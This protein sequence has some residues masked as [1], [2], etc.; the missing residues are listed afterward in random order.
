MLMEISPSQLPM[1]VCSLYI[2]YQSFALFLDA[3][4]S[5]RGG[6]F[7]F[8]FLDILFFSRKNRGDPHFSELGEVSTSVDALCIKMR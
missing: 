7:D 8:F 2:I 1:V 4:S 5:D 3:K 6:F